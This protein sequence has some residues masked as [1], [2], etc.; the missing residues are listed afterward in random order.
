M[1]AQTPYCHFLLLFVSLWA[2]VFF[3]LRVFAQKVPSPFRGDTPHF[4]LID[5]IGEVRISIQVLKISHRSMFGPPHAW[6]LV[7]VTD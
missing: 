2:I 5:V 6:E 1:K 3:S 4:Q 7:M